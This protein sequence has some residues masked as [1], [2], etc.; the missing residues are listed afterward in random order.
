[1]WGSGDLSGNGH[2]PRPI[3]ASDLAAP[4]R[5]GIGG[6]LRLRLARGF[7]T[8]RF[9]IAILGTALGVF[10]AAAGVYTY[11]WVHFSHLIDER[12]GGQVFGHTSH[13]FSAPEK[14]FVGEQTSPG[15]LAGYLINNGYSEADV[16]GA[17]GHFEVANSSIQ[18][19]PS[20]GSYFQGHNSLRVD[21]STDKISGIHLL[22]NELSVSSAEIEPELLTNLFDDSREKRRVVRYEDLPPILVHAVLAA[23]DKRFFDH[24]GLDPI[25][26]LGAAVADLRRNSSGGGMLEG[27]STIDMQVARSFFFTTQRIWRRKLAETM[28]ALEL[29]H[30][31]T[32]QRIFELYANEIYLGNRGSFAIRGFGEAAEAYFGKTFATW[33]LRS[34]RSSRESS[35]P[36]IAT[37][38]SNAILSASTNPATAC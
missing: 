30:R 8:S 6:T 38:R 2:F 13:I 11:Y 22:S 25:R 28:V 32:K 26:V 14:I 4:E 24:G 23:E 1:M 7:W 36:R 10:L 35:A 27:A 21:F 18:I 34:A 12:L 15:N 19:Y 33:T 17:A 31:F 9:G 5:V 3:P 29:D 37:L 16:P 20:D